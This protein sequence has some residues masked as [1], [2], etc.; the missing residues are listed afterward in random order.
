[1]TSMKMK[2][3]RGKSIFYTICQFK[4]TFK[5][6]IHFLKRRFKSVHRGVND[7]IDLLYQQNCHI[8]N[9]PVIVMRACYSYP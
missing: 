7:F 4:C 1:M 6:I 9:K 5:K 2:P 3:V 8:Y